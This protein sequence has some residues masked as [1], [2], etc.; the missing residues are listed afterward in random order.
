MLANEDFYKSFVSEVLFNEEEYFNKEGE[1]SLARLNRLS[2][3]L[4]DFGVPMFEVLTKMVSCRS[5][6]SNLRILD[7]SFNYSF[8]WYWCQG[9]FSSTRKR[10]RRR[11]RFLSSSESRFSF[12][13][14]MQLLDDWKFGFDFFH[15]SEKFQTFVFCGC[16]T[17]FVRRNSKFGKEKMKEFLKEFSD[18]DNNSEEEWCSFRKIRFPRRY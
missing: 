13:W 14:R 3:K 8:A 17:Q 12:P 16:Q 10:R 7:L 11:F 18:F 5:L 9:T 1:I 4:L 2:F 6:V 15:A